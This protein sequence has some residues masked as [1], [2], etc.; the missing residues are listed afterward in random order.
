MPEDKV[1][2]IEQLQRE[3]HRVAMVGDG[4]NDASALARSDMGIA[5]GGGG[6]RAALET[7]DIALMT[8]DLSKIAGARDRAACLPNDSGEPFC[9][10]GRP[11]TSW[12]HSGATWMDR[13]D[14][15]S[16]YPL[17]SGC[18]GIRQLRAASA[19]ADRGGVVPA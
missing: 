10:C 12:Q 19:R 6:T 11:C 1:K 18:A 16:D 9:G 4:V 17:G 13:A 14:P 8:D 3:V 5:M 15:G 7:A 2:A